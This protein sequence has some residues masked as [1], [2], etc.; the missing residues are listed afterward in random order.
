MSDANDSVP[1]APAAVDSSVIPLPPPTTTPAATD[2]LES[3]SG[4]LDALL[5]MAV[6]ALA[7][8]LASFVARNND[9]WQHLAAGRL[10]TQGQYTFGVNPFTYTTADT[11]W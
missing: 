5:A 2:S 1:A 4:Q 11:Y 3:V 6:L 8:L 9:L 10:L 7:F